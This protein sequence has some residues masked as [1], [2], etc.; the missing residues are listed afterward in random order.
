L[1]FLYTCTRDP[2]LFQK[3]KNIAQCAPVSKISVYNN[4]GLLL[5][6][7]KKKTKKVPEFATVKK[8][9]TKKQPMTPRTKMT[10]ETVRLSTPESQR[11]KAYE[12]WLKGNQNTSNSKKQLK[13]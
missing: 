13:F 5:S 2:E 6:K 1:L 9:K 4:M 3:K 11:K 8:T 7:P 12:R 10:R